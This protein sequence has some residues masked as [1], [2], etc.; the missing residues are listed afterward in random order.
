MTIHQIDEN[1]AFFLI[2]AGFPPENIK[3]YEFRGFHLREISFENDISGPYDAVEM[4]GKTYGLFSTNG[5]HLLLISAGKV[6][7]F[8]IDPLRLNDGIVVGSKYGSI[9]YQR[10]SRPP[11]KTL[12][13]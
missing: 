10:D 2:L 11:K 4:D 1:V 7:R 3:T 9:R 5:G 12:S 13:D 8:N 6:V